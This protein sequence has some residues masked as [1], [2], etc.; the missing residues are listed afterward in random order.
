MRNVFWIITYVVINKHPYL[1]SAKALFL[2]AKLI[3]MKRDEIGTSP[4]YE[5][6]PDKN[7]FYDKR[8]IFSN[9]IQKFNMLEQ[10][11]K[12]RSRSHL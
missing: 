6:P 12:W 3:S 11:T 7:L 8:N 5:I 4:D 2:A 10:A 1:K 9:F